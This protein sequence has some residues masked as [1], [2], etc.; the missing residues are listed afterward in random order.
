MDYPNG[1]LY[2]SEG[3][4]QAQISTI[5]IYN[6]NNQQLEKFS[7]KESLEWTFSIAPRSK[8]FLYA[9]ISGFLGKID[10][11]AEVITFLKDIKGNRIEI[12]ESPIN[13]LKNGNELLFSFPDMRIAVYQIDTGT[14]MILPNFDGFLFPLLAP[15]EEFI[16]ADNGQV[17]PFYSTK[18]NFQPKINK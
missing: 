12:G 2:I 8:L 13:L 4:N 14:I 11:D 18:F 1:Q 15:S 5:Y 6:F 16:F 7:F 10:L 9:N 3:G 17:R